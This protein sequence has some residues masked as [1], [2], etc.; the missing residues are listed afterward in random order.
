MVTASDPRSDSASSRGHRTP[1]AGRP[2]TSSGRARPVPTVPT[3]AGRGRVADA[4][5]ARAEALRARARP[6]RIR[7][8]HRRGRL[9]PAERIWSAVC[10][11][12]APARRTSSAQDPC[13][14]AIRGAR[15]RGSPGPSHARAAVGDIDVMDPALDT[16]LGDVEIPILKRPRSVDDDCRSPREERAHLSRVGYVDG[17]RAYWSRSERRR[18]RRRPRGIAPRD[19]QLQLGMTRERCG[20]TASEHAVSAE[21]DNR[22]RHGRRVYDRSSP[23][24]FCASARPNQSSPASCARSRSRRWRSYVASTSSIRSF[25]SAGKKSAGINAW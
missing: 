9:H 4:P 25:R 6:V 14:H 10:A 5:S 2:A 1:A 12:C 18:K 22:G 16:R 17:E 15:H 13:A 24:P 8:V 19:E 23:A 7:R 21:H 3:T 11:A 20:D